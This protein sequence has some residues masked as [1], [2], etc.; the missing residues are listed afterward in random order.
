MKF[1]LLIMFFIFIAFLSC[2]SDDEVDCESN[3]DCLA[4]ETCNLS[5]NVCE[6]IAEIVDEE[7]AADI[8]S[9]IPVSDPDIISPDEDEDEIIE[10]P[11]PDVDTSD[12][13]CTPGTTKKCA[14]VGSEELENVGICKA[15]NSICGADAKWSECSGQ[16]NPEAEAC[17]A[18]GIDSDCNGNPDNLPAHTDSDGD[19][20]F[21]CEDDAC[22][23]ES[24]C[25][26][27]DPA[28]INP[29][30]FEVAGNGIDDNSNGEIDE[31]PICETGI[32]MTGI[33]GNGEYLAKAMDICDGF[34]SA[35]ISLAGE[36][37]TETINGSAR[38][39]LTMPY[40]DN[41]YKTYAVANKFGDVI[42]S[43]KG[44]LMAILSTGDYDSPTMNF[45]EA[46]LEAGDMKTAS[47][48][49]TDWI[50]RQK[51]CKSPGSEA[52]GETISTEELDNQCEGKEIPSVQ[53]PIMLT[54]KVK[55]PINANAFSFDFYFFSIEFP[56]LV[57]S[58]YNDFFVAL[59]DSTFNE[60]NPDSDKKNNWDKN[61]AVDEKGNP[62]GV[63][64]APNGIFRKCMPSGCS[65]SGGGN[66]YGEC[67]ACADEEE[68][69]G[70]G[71]EY[72]CTSFIFFETCEGHGG[73]GW[74]EASGNVVPGEEITLRFALW[75]TGS[76]EY[77]TDHSYDTTVLLDNFK[78]YEKEVEPGISPK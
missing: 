68:L 30:A 23:I 37:V 25:P 59:L 45:T 48:V 1:C 67:D 64:I 47:K 50:N 29:N 33:E 19:G 40:F 60:V 77:G 9:Q 65:D 69:E 63:N 41:N 21:R 18:D 34:V 22:D 56:G 8:D 54:V 57:C 27:Y 26:G 72:E 66:T 3:E 11:D 53:D 15:G 71:F 74:Y 75:E 14:W 16:V 17:L 24:E 76:V 44:S 42:T 5:L 61:M 31:L 52:C 28:M 43:E 73:T 32:S 49:P 70:T 35:E 39:S 7:P 51:D 20:F 58:Q 36:P 6:E 10:T 55:V 46:T 13:P 2:T 38:A 78:W 62:M 12:E 4:G